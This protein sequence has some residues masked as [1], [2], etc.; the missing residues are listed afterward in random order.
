MDKP[1]IHLHPV[2]ANAIIKVDTVGDLPNYSAGVPVG[3]TPVAYV[4]DLDTFYYFDGLAWSEWPS[5]AGSTGAAYTTIATD[6]G[7]FP[8]ATTPSETLQLTSA[9]GSIAITGNQ[10]LDQVNLQV[11]SSSPGF[12]YTRFGDVFPGTWLMN[13]QIPSN[14]AGRQVY[15]NSPAVANISV[16][17]EFSNT[18]DLDIYEHDGT[19]FTNLGTVSI[20]NQRAVDFT[21]S[22]SL[23]QGKELAVQLSSGQARNLIVSAQIK[24]SI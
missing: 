7:T 24:G 10:G 17:N 23:T 12:T 14:V 6:A 18:F 16:S 8:I 4:D 1:F 13:G 9:D 11:N 2:V 22:L 15:V 21:V 20:I 3:V 19:T 5:G